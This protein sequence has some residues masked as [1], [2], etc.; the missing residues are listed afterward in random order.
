MNGKKPI[1]SL[2]GKEAAPHLAALEALCFSTP[3]SEDQYVRILEEADCLRQRSK[4]RNYIPP[5]AVFGMYDPAWNLVAYMSLSLVIT[6]GEAEIF[7]IA[8][9]PELR[10]HG[11]AKKLLSEVLALVKK[12]GVVIVFL[13]VRTSNLPAIGLYEGLGFTKA[14]MR[15]KY[16]ADTGEDALILRLDMV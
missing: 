12:R 4:D 14:G 16:Y 2:L 8:V 3:W 11:L 9:Q 1:I 13:E 15:K 7:N 6:T 10:Q 5:Y